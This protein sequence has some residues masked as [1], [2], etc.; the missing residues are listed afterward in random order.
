MWYSKHLRRL[1]RA[2]QLAKIQQ[3]QLVDL[4]LKGFVALTV[5]SLTQS[6]TVT[7]EHGVANV[8]NN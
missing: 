8:A 2:R 6:I 5:H 4:E 7:V 3:E 1:R